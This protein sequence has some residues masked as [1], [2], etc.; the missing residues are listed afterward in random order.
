MPLYGAT[1]VGG[2]RIEVD[3]H[4]T[5][6]LTIAQV[7]NTIIYNTG[8]AA[9]NVALAMPEVEAG[10]DFIATVGTAQA[11]N[12]W[13][14]VAYAGDVIYLDGAAGGAGE[15]VKVTPVVG[16]NIHFTAFNISGGHAWLAETGVGT[17]TA[18]EP[19]LEVVTQPAN[20]T[21]TE[22]ETAS[23]FIVAIGANAYQWQLDSGAGFGDIAGAES[24]SYTTPVL[25]YPDDNANEYRCKAIHGIH[26]VTSSAAVLTVEETVI[27]PEITVQPDDAEKDAGLTATF[28]ITATGSGITYQW[29]LKVPAGAW[30]DIVG[31]ESDS[32]E[33]PVLVYPDDNGNQ[34]RCV[35]T[36]AAGDDTSDAATLTVGDLVYSNTGGA[37]T[38]DGDYKVHTFLLAQTGTNFVA[39]KEG[40]V[41]CLV[42]AGGGGGGG[43]RGAGGGAGGYVHNASFA[44]TSSTY[45]IT[46][47]AGGA[48]GSIYGYDGSTGNNS[49][50]STITAIGGGGGGG[51]AYPSG[52]Q[53]GSGG[54]A[55]QGG[56]IGDADYISPR[57]GYDGGSG[58]VSG[59]YGGGGGGGSSGVGNNGVTTPNGTQAAGGAGTA[60]SISGSSVT[61]SVGGGGGTNI[62]TSPPLSLHGDGANGTPNTGNGG[63]G[64]DNIAPEYTRA[65]A[66][67]S[68]GSGIVII[69]CLT[70][71]FLEPA[72]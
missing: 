37:I 49:V 16:D 32:Y 22:G 2:V 34:Y 10:Y 69:R 67:G 20:D 66:G 55:C 24:A 71:D 5:A 18:A 21:V 41:E 72:P 11:G 14:F 7:K 63:A 1:G 13:E 33:T 58:A 52:K 50:F 70:A 44:V 65:G 25:V 9:A 6:G 68:G 36:N 31:A 61:Y 53:G 35:A 29:Q 19:T 40:N 47:G 48:G 45:T 23:F 43:S 15:S 60:N 4:V 64:G 54:G 3:G 51:A 59:N 30:G 17:W 12:T 8:Q 39:C 57:Q 27:P 56:T 38:T 62:G 26:S 42:I 28:D 46:V